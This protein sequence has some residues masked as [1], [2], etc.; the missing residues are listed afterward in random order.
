MACVFLCDRCAHQGQLTTILGKD[1]CAACITELHAWLVV[2][3]AMKRGSK[4]NR[5]KQAQHM[6][7]RNGYVSAEMMA[8][9]NNEP[10]RRAY[11][12][13]RA[14]AKVGKLEDKGGGVFVAI[15]QERAA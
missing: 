9:A 11:W 12:G 4:I 8:E 15:K 5:V 7:L 10:T 2:P 6:L 1:I 3:A 14:L 13:L